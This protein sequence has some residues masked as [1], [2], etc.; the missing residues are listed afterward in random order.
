MVGRAAAA[1]SSNGSLFGSN[2][3]WK[4]VA[5]FTSINQIDQFFE[6]HNIVIEDS[7]V[8]WNCGKTW[9]LST[10]AENGSCE[11]KIIIDYSMNDDI[12]RST[13]NYDSTAHR[14]HN[15]HRRIDQMWCTRRSSNHTVCDAHVSFRPASASKRP[16][17]RHLFAWCHQHNI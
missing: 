10:D 16:P 6:R 9:R 14:N 5:S 8:Q 13:F 4:S 12:I 7:V 2:W 15:R 11:W 1:S 3:K 17:A